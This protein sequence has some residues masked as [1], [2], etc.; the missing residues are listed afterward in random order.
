MSLLDYIPGGDTV[1]IVLAVVAFAAVTGAVSIAVHKY[2][3][4]IREPLKKELRLSDDM[5]AGCRKNGESLKNSIEI[6]NKAIREI[7]ERAAKRLDDSQ[8]AVAEAKKLTTKRN[9]S[10]KEIIASAPLSP[11]L[12]ESAR[13]RMVPQ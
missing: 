13:L 1:K 5:L 3:N 8:K 7:N 6:Q 9:Q 10:V 12:C 2:N 4:W 11:D